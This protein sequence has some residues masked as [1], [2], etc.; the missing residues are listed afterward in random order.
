MFYRCHKKIIKNNLVENKI[1]KEGFWSVFGQF[2]SA[3][4]IIAGIRAVT[5]YVTP[6]HYGQ[7]IIFSG[8]TLLALNVFSGSIFQSFLRIIPEKN[9]KKLYNKSIVLSSKIVFLFIGIGL[10]FLLLNTLFKSNILFFIFVFFI[11]L[12]S[13]HFVGL[14]KVLMNIKKEQKKYAFFQI[15]ISILRPIAA[16]LLYIYHD[17]NFV[18]IVYGF[19]IAN[20]FISIIFFGNKIIKDL[21]IASKEKFNW[22]NFSEFFDFSK[23]LIF[24]KICGWTLSNADKYIIAFFLGTAAAG[25]Y[26]PIVSLVSMLYLT[27]SSAVE[28][29]FRPYYFEYIAQGKIKD[30]KKILKRYARSLFIASIAFIILFTIFN[31]EIVSLVLGKNFRDYYTLLPTL[32]IGFSFLIFGYLFENICFAYKKTWAVFF[33]EG[34]A[35]ITNIVV[36]PIMVYNFGIDGIP[37]ALLF[38][39]IAHF[40]S[41]LI[42]TRRKILK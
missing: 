14:F 21:I 27:L 8:I 26:A 6:E 5:E 11:Y 42:I 23:P 3:I 12:I 7:Y 20:F 18:S 22:G 19:C 17:N 30:G 4:A 31:Q 13:E 24:Q 38:V 29:I 28:L 2:F 15:S 34:I 39:Y 32:S 40:M 36:L 1:L 9:D 41:G 10:F 37:Y 33:I 35:A 16:V 25:K